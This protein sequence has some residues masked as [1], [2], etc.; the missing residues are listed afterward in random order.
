MNAPLGCD[1]VLTS[2]MKQET[3]CTRPATYHL[4]HWPEM[5]SFACEQHVLGVLDSLY[6]LRQEDG[7][8]RGFTVTPIRLLPR[9][10]ARELGHH[11]S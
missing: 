5:I 6:E 9:Q 7:E 4:G 8:R 10:M 2:S 1:A 3:R 11:P